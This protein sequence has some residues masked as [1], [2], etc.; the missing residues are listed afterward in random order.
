M[1][2]FP[3]PEHGILN[4]F[5][6]DI[7]L[8]SALVLFSLLR[9]IDYHYNKRHIEEEFFKCN[10]IHRRLLR[11]STLQSTSLRRAIKLVLVYIIAI[12]TCRCTFTPMSIDIQSF[13]ILL[14]LTLKYQR[15]FPF[16][17]ISGLLFCGFFEQKCFAAI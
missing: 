1:V 6:N 11:I 5:I 2:N 8:R 13:S 9:E 3:G 10:S 17:L 16:L 14:R 4:S 7:I 15:T 12:F